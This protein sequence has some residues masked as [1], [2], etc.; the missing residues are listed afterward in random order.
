MEFF[1][2]NAKVEGDIK[3][4]AKNLEIIRKLSGDVRQFQIEEN[5]PMPLG[6]EAFDLVFEKL[7]FF[8]GDGYNSEFFAYSL[9]EYANL[10]TPIGVWLKENAN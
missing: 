1:L 5:K 2:K 8:R 4:H 9:T 6:Y 3:C 7:P 10:P